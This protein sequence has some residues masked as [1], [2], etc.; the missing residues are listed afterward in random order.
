MLFSIN[1]LSFAYGTDMIFDDV[2]YTMKEKEHIGLIGANGSGKTTF[3]KLLNHVL[4]PDS[5]TIHID[6]HCRMGTLKQELIFDENETLHQFLL[7]HFSHLIRMEEE[8][9]ALQKQID[10]GGNTQKAVE[11]LGLLQDKYA[12]QGGYEYPSRIRGVTAG[13]GFTSD[14]LNRHFDTFSG[15]QKTRIALSALL[16][17]EPDLLLLDEPTNYLD[18]DTLSW[19]ENYLKGYDKGFI[20]IS[21]DRYFLDHVATKITAVENHHLVSFNGNYSDYLDKKA[22]QDAAAH[23][24]AEKNNKEIARQ[25]KIIAD[26]RARHSVKAIRRAK[27]REVKLEKMDVIKESQAA[28]EISLHFTPRIRSADDVLKVKHLSKSFDGHAILDDINFEIF[29]GDKI[30]LIGNNGTG[31]STLLRILNRELPADGGRLIYGQKVQTG[32]YSQESVNSAAYGAGNLI[33]ALRQVD[34][35]LSDGEARNILARFLFFGDDVFKETASL[36][37]GEMARLRLAMLMISERNFLLLD[38]PTNHIDT[39]TKEIMED[40]L[41]D[42][43]GTILAVSHDRYFLNKVATKIFVLTHH[44]IEIYDGNYDDYREHI[45]QLAQ[46][47]KAAQKMAPQMTKT[48]QKKSAKAAHQKQQAVRRQKSKLK[49]LE[50]AIEQLDSDIADIEAAM[51]APDFYDDAQKAEATTQ[52]YQALKKDSDAKMREWENLA[53]ALEDEA[54]D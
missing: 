37:G 15:G 40:A 29:R 27:S 2:S 38:E 10:D 19:L 42:Y 33:D 6:A 12:A 16:L 26:L 52:R 7:S 9:A 5:G 30:G 51:C 53:T 4:I 22:K 34:L 1:H 8:M 32:Y 20:V 46:D 48:A 41:I 47:R 54:T 43:D 31:K 21:H 36:S 13:L 50:Q 35:R 17:S 44:G 25:Q 24:A 3:F 11:Q 28:T 18:L 49:K 23:A 45:A 14:D 39:T